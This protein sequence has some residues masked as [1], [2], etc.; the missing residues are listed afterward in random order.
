MFGDPSQEDGSSF[1]TPMLENLHLI[2]LQLSDL[3]GA[4][5]FHQPPTGLIQ[6]R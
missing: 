5:V 4:N 3:R 1:A 6:S 2:K